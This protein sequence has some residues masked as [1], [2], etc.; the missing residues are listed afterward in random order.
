VQVDVAMIGDELLD[1]ACRPRSSPQ[2]TI[3]SVENDRRLRAHT[4]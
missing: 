1:S 4:A 2:F 3:L